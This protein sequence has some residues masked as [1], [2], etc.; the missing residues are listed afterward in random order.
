MKLGRLTITASR[1]PWQ[2]Y[3]WF[4]HKNNQGPTAMLNPNGA[5]FGAGWKYK[6]GFSLGGTTLLIDALF[7]IIRI[8]WEPRK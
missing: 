2:G 3:G 1:F 8:S 6:L 5:R 4:P 7:G